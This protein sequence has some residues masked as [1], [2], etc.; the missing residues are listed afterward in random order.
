MTVATFRAVGSRS[1]RIAPRPTPVGALALLLVLIGLSGAPRLVA[2]E[3][4]PESRRLAQEIDRR[5]AEHWASR[6]VVPAAGA[7]EAALYRR[8]ALDLTGRVPTVPEWR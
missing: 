6:G 7:E 2:A 8:A 5:M 1:A 4:A 3:D